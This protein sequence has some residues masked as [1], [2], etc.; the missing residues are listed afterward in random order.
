MPTKDIH[1]FFEKSNKEG[2]GF[3]V[4]IDYL[5]G[6]GRAGIVELNKYSLLTNL[7]IQEST[8]VRRTF[9]VSENDFALHSDGTVSFS[10][11]CSL[12]VKD[13]PLDIIV[14]AQFVVSKAE[15]S[16]QFDAR[17][18]DFRLELTNGTSA[19]KS[20]G[21]KYSANADALI[22]AAGYAD[23]N[24]FHLSV[25]VPHVHVGVARFLSP[26]LS[27]IP[28]PPIYSS[29]GPFIPVPP[30][31]HAA[32]HGHLFVWSE[33][34]S[35]ALDACSPTRVTPV[36]DGKWQ[37]KPGT[38]GS[39]HDADDLSFAVHVPAKILSGFYFDKLLPALM[40]PPGE[41]PK[42]TLRFRATVT[43]GLKSFELFL[44]PSPAGGG[45]AVALEMSAT[46]SCDAWADFGIV[47]LGLGAAVYS[48]D[49]ST[50]GSAVFDIRPDRAGLRFQTS[51]KISNETLILHGL[52]AFV[53]PIVKLI[54]N[55]NVSDAQRRIANRGEITLFDA[56]AI[57][58]ANHMTTFHRVGEE[59]LLIGM[60]LGLRKEEEEKA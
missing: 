10:Y 36:N 47:K 38:V 60:K 19:I 21:D 15:V 22:V 6:L 9:V 25:W 17:A 3:S 12:H 32:Q 1:S 43:V 14:S 50:T 42:G 16:L 51:G 30:F 41:T 11:R 5:Q 24:D 4:A 55:I 18:N 20:G 37:L 45:L 46:G 44:T 49:V 40:I 53:E 31:R 59:S 29:F 33:K 27:A 54:M 48:S 39:P 57:A 28:L 56:G 8:T 26:I 34:A 52:A 23:R 7:Q 35:A 2:L 13:A 58:A